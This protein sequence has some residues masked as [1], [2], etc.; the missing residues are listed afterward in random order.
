MF[1]QRYVPRPDRDQD[2]YAEQTAY[3]LAALRNECGRV[4]TRKGELTR[5]LYAAAASL[6]E[7]VASQQ[8]TQGV[9]VEHLLRLRGDVPE[10]TARQ[11]ILA[12]LEKGMRNPR[13]PGDRFGNRLASV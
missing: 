8:L 6:G 3:G 9:V 11:S 10:A 4:R 13:E 1:S 7:L 2:L 12:G 5:R